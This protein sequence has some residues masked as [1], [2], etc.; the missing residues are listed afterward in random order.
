MVARAKRSVPEHVWV[1]VV[2]IKNHGD[3]VA[4]GIDCV[5]QVIVDGVMWVVLLITIA[6]LR[7]G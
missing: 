5:I 7:D 6:T 4:V 2:M 3:A 1:L